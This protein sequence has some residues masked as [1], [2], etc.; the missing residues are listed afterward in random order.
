MTALPVLWFVQGVET[1][2]MRSRASN[3][4]SL[5]EMVR[6][7]P[8]LCIAFLAGLCLAAV[9]ADVGPR[10][11]LNW[12]WTVLGFGFHLT[13]GWPENLIP[14]STGWLAIGMG[15]VLGLIPYVLAD[16]VWRHIRQR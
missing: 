9:E 8:F 6:D 7:N 10:E 15:I 12:M 11:F 16:I 1:I 4:R 3:T 14:G 5:A 2:M 13:S